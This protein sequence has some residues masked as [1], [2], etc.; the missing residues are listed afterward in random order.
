MVAASLAALQHAPRPLPLFLDLVRQVAMDDPDLA[1]RALAGVR[2][3]SAAARP[4][5][6]EL[7]T[8]RIGPM[9]AH[10]AGE[11]GPP[12][13]LVPSLINPGW[14]LDLDD[15][16][17]LLRWLAAQGFRAML[18]D[19]ESPTAATRELSL[20]GQIEHRLAL[21]IAEVGEPVHLVGYC[22]GGL[23]ALG[24]THMLPADVRSLSLLAT[25]WDFNG[26]ASDA[27][28]RIGG[29]WLQHHTA[30][31]ALGL[32]PMEVL[33]S[34][35]WS[36]EPQRTVAKFA[37]LADLPPEHPQLTAFARLE[38]WANGGAPIGLASGRDLFEALIRD[39][40]T[41]QGEWRVGGVPVRPE[42]LSVPARQWTARND[43]IAPAESA[44]TA[45]DR[46]DAAAGHV[47]MIVGSAAQTQCWQPLADWLAA[48]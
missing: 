46:F 29:L 48:N 5:P 1:R 18:L 13:L 6:T 35:F 21:T 44:C 33:Q 37:A 36:I 15:Q 23:M 39:N 11:R 34:A 41:G 16:R 8:R 24:A 2:A 31:E 9:L 14:V 30:M 4:I 38:D 22:L 27:R 43:R 17:S 32:L 40:R 10:C 26:Y 7:E 45:I 20:A 19:W 47:G 12:V 25:P 42:A 28:D 3:Y